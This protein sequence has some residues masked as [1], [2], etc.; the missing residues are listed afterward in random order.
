MQMWRRVLLGWAACFL[1]ATFCA[2]ND[3]G[4]L[5]TQAG[6]AMTNALRIISEDK[7][8]SILAQ[9]NDKVVVA[10]FWATWCAP[11]REEFPELVKLHRR[12]RERGLV[13][14]A[15][16][17]DD[18]DAIASVK[19]FVAEQKVDFQVYLV[20]LNDQEKFIDTIDKSWPGSIPATFIYDKKGKLAG[21]L[22]GAH[23]LVEFEEAVKPALS[24]Q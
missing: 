8:Q 19:K 21:R 15:F 23:E 2:A 22:I 11:C 5:K 4:A 20:Q 10:N 14:I 1:T 6:G 9:Q 16:A 12:Y 13:V 17:I 7:V 24:V 3:A 18:V